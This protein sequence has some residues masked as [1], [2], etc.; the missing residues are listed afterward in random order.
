VDVH[1]SGVDVALARVFLRIGQ[2]WQ[3]FYPQEVKSE[4]ID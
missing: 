1:L 4:T 2:A 3:F